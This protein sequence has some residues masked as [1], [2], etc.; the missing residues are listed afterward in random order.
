MDPFIAQAT[1]LKGK[2]T[3]KPEQSQPTTEVPS[4]PSK[5]PRRNLKGGSIE[6]MAE[7]AAK[8]LGFNSVTDVMATFK[9][10]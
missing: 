10:A 6:E 3:Q 1:L 9:N 7:E 4:K 8:T 2:A 5:A